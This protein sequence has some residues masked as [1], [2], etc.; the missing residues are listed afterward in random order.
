MHPQ[1]L[2]SRLQC[3]TTADAVGLSLTKFP[4]FDEASVVAVMMGP[5]CAERSKSQSRARVRAAQ[6]RL[7]STDDGTLRS[8]PYEVSHCQSVTAERGSTG[9]SEISATGTRSHLTHPVC[10][11]SAR[12]SSGDQSR[13]A[14][15]LGCQAQTHQVLSA[16]SCRFDGFICLCKVIRRRCI[17]LYRP[18][19][20]LHGA[21]VRR[22]P[23]LRSSGCPQ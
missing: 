16:R 14:A 8:T 18:D 15:P 7:R 21:G 5:R 22:L 23:R 4:S 3:N 6:L 17:R 12:S 11:C 2:A 19:C 1:A 13:R 9:A 20:M 10:Q